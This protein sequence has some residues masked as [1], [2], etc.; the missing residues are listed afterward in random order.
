MI[1][2]KNIFADTLHLFYPHICT[3]CG[4]DLIAKESLL[5]IQ[6]IN[7]LPHTG[8]ADHPNNPIEKVFAGRIPF[9][10]AHSE[11]YFSKGQLLQQLIHLLKYKNNKEIGHYLGEL[12]G[13]S[14]LRSNRFSQIDYL[15][16]L[17]LFAEKEFKRGYNQA[18]IICNGI[19]E[20][21]QIPVMT[22]NVIRRHATETQTRKHRAERWQNV[23]DSFMILNPAALKGKNL[24]LVD[25]V[26]TTGATLEACGQVILQIPGTRISFATLAHASK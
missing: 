25:D 7:D 22:K 21:T 11:F 2:L 20:A 24:L 10:T 4:S 26:I 23:A 1:A 3:G 6:C 15:V 18:E 12:M 19:Y 13:N 5:C 9:Q 16:P 17:P 8:F 14:L